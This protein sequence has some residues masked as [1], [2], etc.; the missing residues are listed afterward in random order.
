MDSV[1]H[2]AVR[3]G[4]G[5]VHAVEHHRDAMGLDLAVGRQ[6]GDEG[7]AAE[8]DVAAV[9]QAQGRRLANEIVAVNDDVDRHDAV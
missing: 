2:V 4:A 1:P 5:G 9:Q 7:L 3:R 8:G 6:A